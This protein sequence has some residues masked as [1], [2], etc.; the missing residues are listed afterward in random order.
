MK[1][2]TSDM[3]LSPVSGRILCDQNYIP[4]GNGQGI[5]T[6]SPILIDIRLDFNSLSESNFVL[7]YPSF[8]APNA[9]VLSNLAN[10]LMYNT[11]GIVST[12]GATSFA[13]SNSNYILQQPDDELP[14]AQALSGLGG[15]ILKSALTTGIVSIAVGGVDYATLANVAAAESAAITA[16]ASASVLFF[17][18]QMTP[19]TTSPLPFAG[20]QIAL[21]IAAASAVGAAA[22]VTANNANTRVDNLTVTL[23]GDVTGSHNINGSVETTFCPNPTFTGAAV[24]IPS[25][26]TASRPTVF[27]QGMIRL[28]TGFYLL[29]VGI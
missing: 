22:Q 7:G 4:L 3:F 14:N 26:D 2:T 29:E 15:G 8:Q 18:S 6:P 16:A 1:V 20:A 21:S 28:N 13:P 17:T 23:A 5:A 11:A 10:G 9:Q 19:F 27:S 25:G 24:T 12:V